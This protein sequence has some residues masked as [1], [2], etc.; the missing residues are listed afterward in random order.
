MPEF[1]DGNAPSALAADWEA[2]PSTQT[3]FDELPPVSP[4]ARHG[5]V[6]L[7]QLVNGMTSFQFEWIKATAADLTRHHLTSLLFVP[8]HGSFG[9]LTGVTQE[10]TQVALYIADHPLR[11]ANPEAEVWIG[12]YPPTTDPAFRAALRRVVTGGDE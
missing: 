9:L 4:D 2:D 3:V 1:N 11:Y 12:E 7:D 5:S 10:P 6:N 8:T